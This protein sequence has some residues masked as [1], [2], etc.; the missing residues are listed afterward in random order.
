MKCLVTGASGFIGGHLV[1]RLL[2][3]GHD[4][5]VLVR[6]TSI[7][8]AF[9]MARVV[10]H[11]GD[12]R[13]TGSVRRA[14]E[15]MECVFHL[16]AVLRARS[17]AEYLAVNAEGTRAVAEAVRDESQ[18][19]GGA[20]VRLV[21]LS[22]LAAGGPSYDG[23]PVSAEGTPHP[24]SDY[25][26]TKLAGETMIR[27]VLEDVPWVALRPPPVYGPRDRDVLNLFRMLKRGLMPLIG[28]G[29]QKIPL[30]HI[31]DM[32]TA[33]VLAGESDRTGRVYYVTDGDLRSWR[34][35][36]EAMA[37]ALG[38][39]PIRLSVP[40]ALVSVVG[41]MGQL[42]SDLTGRPVILNRDKAAEIVAPDWACDDRPARREL[43]FEPRFSLEEGLADAIAWYRREK[44]L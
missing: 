5:H 31:H 18:A 35:I 20:P 41:A 29:A 8:T 14:V 9:D 26:R 1:E 32:A 38:V 37:R 43:G 6:K 40:N 33:A 4:V 24:I 39:R 30:I 19:R 23:L 25:G 17:P 11:E 44:W 7:T 34:E 13:D 27:S 28:G 21:Y 16:A 22:S 10:R 3:K 36:V 42:F 15:G 12:L 2:E